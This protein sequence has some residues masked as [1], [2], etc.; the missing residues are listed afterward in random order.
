MTKESLNPN[1]LNQECGHSGLVIPS[2]LGFSHSPETE[3]A[4][5]DEYS[6]GKLFKCGIVKRCDESEH[7]GVLK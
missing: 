1:D 7:I 2:S 4:L 6:Q 5:L 3:M